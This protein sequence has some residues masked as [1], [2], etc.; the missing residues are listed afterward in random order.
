[1]LTMPGTLSRLGVRLLIVVGATLGP[2]AASEAALIGTLTQDSPTPTTYTLNVDFIPLSFSPLASATGILQPVDLLLPPTGGS[3][4]GCEAADFVGFMAG[5]IA[6]V[7]RGACLFVVKAQN[8]QAAGAS[9]VIIFN[10]GNTP[11]RSDLLQGSLGANTLLIPVVG[12]TFALGEEFEQLLTGTISMSVT[13][14]TPPELAPEPASLSLL[15][16][17]LG[18]L[19]ARRRAA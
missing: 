10:E 14:S 18:L 1:M 16:I 19:A 6:L 17:G 8:A 4:S 15:A 11:E 13:D 2:S 12:T 3:N 7:Q 5:N 9:G